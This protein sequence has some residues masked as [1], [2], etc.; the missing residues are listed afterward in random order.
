MPRLLYEKNISTINVRYYANRNIFKSCLV[1]FFAWNF[2]ICSLFSGNDLIIQFLKKKINSYWWSFM[3]DKNFC[4]Q[5]YCFWF[6]L[7][8]VKNIIYQNFLFLLSP[9]LATPMRHPVDFQDRKNDWNKRDFWSCSTSRKTTLN[10]IRRRPYSFF[11]E[12]FYITLNISQKRHLMLSRKYLNTQ[13]FPR[14]DGK[15]KKKFPHS[16]CQVRKRIKATLKKGKKFQ[17]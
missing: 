11:I 8:L 7:Y 15:V 10:V 14:S 1:W 13:V 6:V 17:L 3:K 16:L 12:P 4:H 2:C 5:V 9:V